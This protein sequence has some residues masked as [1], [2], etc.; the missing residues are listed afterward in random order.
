MTSWR[1]NTTEQ[2][3]NDVDEM[4]DAALNA[5]QKLLAENGEF[6]PFGL[7]V[8]SDGVLRAFGVDESVLP[9]EPASKD[10]VE[11][12]QAGFASGRAELRAVAVVADVRLKA[13][14]GDAINVSLEHSEGPAMNV[15]LPYS[16]DVDSADIDYGEA[17]ATPGRRRIWGD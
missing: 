8:A 14:G 16:R 5:A 11:A 7:G 13:G 9:A 6:L 2:T 3:Q 1:D 12:L 15:Q 17:S 10:V 4:V